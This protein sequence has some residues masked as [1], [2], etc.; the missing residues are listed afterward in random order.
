MYS[1][2]IILA[3]SERAAEKAALMA[4]MDPHGFTITIVAV[5]VVFTSLFLLY[6]AYSLVGWICSGKLRVCFKKRR[7]AVD[8]ID[9]EVVA[10]ISMALDLS[11]QEEECHD[12]ES[13][14]ITIRRK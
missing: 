3:I 9:D 1:E 5:A 13:Y 7:K 2:L 11:A 4:E 12:R 14:V 10:A 8:G 6:L